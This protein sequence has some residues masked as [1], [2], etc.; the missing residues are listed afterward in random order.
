MGRLQCK[1]RKGMGLLL[2][3][4]KFHIFRNDYK[5]ILHNIMWSC[6]LPTMCAMKEMDSHKVQRLTTNVIWHPKDKGREMP[7]LMRNVVKKHLKVDERKEWLGELTPIAQTQP[8]TQSQTHL[9]RILQLGN[10]A[11]R[12]DKY[13]E[14][15]KINKKFD[16]VFSNNRALEGHIILFFFVWA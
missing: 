5:S 10:V 7:N 3:D 14:I 11:T 1:E 16:A 6:P 9:M 2:R 13:A 4:M 12:L 15:W 8:H